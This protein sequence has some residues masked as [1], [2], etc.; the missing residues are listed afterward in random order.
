MILAEDGSPYFGGDYQFEPGRADWVRKGT[1]GTIITYGAL[2][3]NVMEAWRKLT[4][5]GFS[6]AVLMSASIAPFDRQSVIEAAKI[7]PILTVEDHHADIG[8][9]SIVGMILAE[10]EIGVAFKRLGV[11]RYGSSGKPADLYAAQGLDGEG[12]AGEFKKLV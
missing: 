6:V 9:G 12:I 2:T 8:L 1:D 11:T 7:G 4:D 3:T 10:E 5:D